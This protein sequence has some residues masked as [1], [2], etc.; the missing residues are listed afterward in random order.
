MFG[1]LINMYIILTIVFTWFFDKEVNPDLAKGIDA[2]LR[3]FHMSG[4]GIFSSLPIVIF[5]FMY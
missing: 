2:A 4:H 3:K 5:S 1:F